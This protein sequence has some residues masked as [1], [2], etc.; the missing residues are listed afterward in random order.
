MVGGPPWFGC[1]RFV[2]I[3]NM[4]KLFPERL[5]GWGMRSVFSVE[6]TYKETAACKIR[7]SQEVTSDPPKTTMEGLCTSCHAPW[8]KNFPHSL[9]DPSAQKNICFCNGREVEKLTPSPFP[10]VLYLKKRYHLSEKV[11]GFSTERTLFSTER[12]IVPGTSICGG[13]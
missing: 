7:N 10:I 5:Q 1:H 11:H 4:C 9:T 13:D 6:T 12:T 3:R 2:G 8:Q